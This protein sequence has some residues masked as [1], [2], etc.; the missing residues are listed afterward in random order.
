M[1]AR[2]ELYADRGVKNGSVPSISIGLT[3]RQELRTKVPFLL[4]PSTE[5]KVKHMT[6]DMLD[7]IM[8]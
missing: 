7:H 4:K 3:V 8:A 1:R 2:S 5:R 6:V